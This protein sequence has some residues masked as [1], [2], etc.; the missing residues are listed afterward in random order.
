[1]NK[2]VPPHHLIT[3]HIPLILLIRGLSARIPRRLARCSARTTPR[4]I[5]RLRFARDGLFALKSLTAEITHG[6]LCSRPFVGLF[7]SC[8]ESV[9]GFCIGCSE[10]VASCSS[11]SE[12]I[13]AVFS[14]RDIVLQCCSFRKKCSKSAEGGVA[15]LYSISPPSYDSELAS[16]VSMISL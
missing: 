4:D 3:A 7:S 9:V 16:S 15:A 5:S 2:Y 8:C 12:L 11:I 1:M 6:G 13:S 14:F 10:K